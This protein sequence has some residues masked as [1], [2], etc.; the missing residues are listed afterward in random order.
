MRGA[1]VGL[2]PYGSVGNVYSPDLNI[3]NKSIGKNY[4]VLRSPPST[5][6]GAVS[7]AMGTPDYINNT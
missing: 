4:G 6:R 5:T 7:A 1:S 2:E 3:Y